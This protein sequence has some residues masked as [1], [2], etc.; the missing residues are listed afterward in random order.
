MVVTMQSLLVLVWWS[1][2]QCATL[3]HNMLQFVAGFGSWSECAAVYYI[4]S[5]CSAVCFSVMQCD[6][7]FH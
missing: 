7:K 5:H 6:A 4:V 2:L 1:V 3:N